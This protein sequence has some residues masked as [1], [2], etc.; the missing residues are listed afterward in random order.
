MIFSLVIK[1]K[2]H[3]M[4]KLIDL[5]DL[6]K[7]EIL[8]LHSAEEQ[9][10]EALPAMI[11]K[12][13]NTALKSAL[14]EHLK[15]TETH[16]KRLEEIQAQM[17]EAENAGGEKDNAEEGERENKRPGFFSRLFSG[18]GTKC[19][20][21][22]GLITEGNKMMGEDMS[23]E[24]LDAAIIASAQ[25]IEHYEICGYGTA[26]AYA[27][28]LQLSDISNMLTQTL[29]E[30]YTADDLLTQLAVGKLNIEAEFAEDTENGKKGR[31]LRTSSPAKKNEGR[32]N[33][34]QGY[35]TSPPKKAAGRQTPVKLT[36]AKT[37]SQQSLKS[38]GDSSSKS[39]NRSVAPSKAVAKAAAKK[40][41]IKQSASSK[42][43]I[44]K[45]SPKKAS[46]KKVSPKKVV[47]KKAAVKQQPSKKVALKK[48]TSSSNSMNKTPGKK[49]AAKKSNIL[50]IRR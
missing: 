9:I 22:E 33:G 36:S 11:E 42:T 28:E 3:S 6:L 25:K 40:P 12:A 18:G 46:P 34:Q 23:P 15:I 19:R 14:N 21:M 20:G 30:E 17:G 39:K 35:K 13:N 38:R 44:K 1:N 27:R 47:P 45:A 8:D 5:R 48:T 4:E 16:K 7:H 50:R 10:I 43:S 37:V 29:N 31:S 24:V 32:G 2:K 49:V 41:P 26:R